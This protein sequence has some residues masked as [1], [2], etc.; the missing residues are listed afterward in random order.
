MLR[1]AAEGPHAAVM[2]IARPI[3]TLLVMTWTLEIQALAASSQKADGTGS[4]AA[5]QGPGGASLVSKYRLEA[6]QY[7]RAA[8]EA[9]NEARKFEQKTKNLVYY[10]GSKTAKLTHQELQ[11][12]H[13][14][15][16][17]NAAWKVQQMLDDPKPVQA[18]A[19]A[20]RATLPYIRAYEG[21]QATSAQ[22][23]RTAQAYA[24]RAN[25]DAGTA[26]Q[27]ATYA[28]Q[29]RLQGDENTGDL[30]E[31]HSR[32]LMTQADSYEGLALKYQGIAKKIHQALPVI[33]RMADA[34]RANTEWEE[35]PERGVLPEHVFTFTIAPPLEMSQDAF[36]SS[37]GT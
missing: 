22:Y 23:G 26:R 16:W 8:Q 28:N 27:L 7:E 18:A 33:K 11:R 15:V 36:G 14:G 24:L 6:Q 31:H 5:G 4:G 29:Y 20:E 21:Y 17:A 13:L 2:A 10:G 25:S 32:Q 9:A 37:Q 35:N 34:E 3:S 1:G 30:Y 19:D 12:R